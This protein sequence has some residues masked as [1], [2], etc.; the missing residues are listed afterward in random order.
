VKTSESQATGT[1]GSQL[2]YERTLPE[3]LTF[4]FLFDNTGLIDGRAKPDG[5]FDDVDRFRKLL[6]GFQGESHEPFHLKLVWGSLIFKGRAT[7][8]GITFK[9]FNPDGQPIRA[10]ARVKF[11]GSIEEK[12]RASRENRSSPDLTHERVVKP[13]ETLPYLC[14]KVYGDPRHY[15]YVAAFNQLD[16]F[17]QLTVGRRIQFPPL[18]TS[19]VAR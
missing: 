13:H 14:F 18:P 12:R 3:E 19:Q 17:R 11:R 1:S 8:V 15:L 5:V 7:E 9:L 16:D 4:D 2:K 6:T 10:V